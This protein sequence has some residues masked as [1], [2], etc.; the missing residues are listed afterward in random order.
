M[1]C[2]KICSKLPNPI[3]PEA[4][5]PC[6]SQCA[7]GTTFPRFKV[8]L[9]PSDA[10]LLLFQYLSSVCETCKLSH[11]HYPVCGSIFAKSP[12]H[13]ENHFLATATALRCAVAITEEYKLTA[14]LKSQHS[15]SSSPLAMC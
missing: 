6:K 3:N 5:S 10:G 12:A 2:I 14:L 7:E 9:S 1:Q 4:R 15:Y 11:I 8:V 13:G